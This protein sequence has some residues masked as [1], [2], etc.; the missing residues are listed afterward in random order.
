MEID[1]A[2]HHRRI[3]ARLRAKAESVEAEAKGRADDLRRQA[4]EYEAKAKGRREK[5]KSR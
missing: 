5:R 4:A 3:A 2:E 1:R